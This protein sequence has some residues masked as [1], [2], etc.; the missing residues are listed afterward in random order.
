M[1]ELDM[2]V[3]RLRRENAEPLQMHQL[4]LAEIVRLRRMIEAIVED[5]ERREKHVS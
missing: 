1:T 5:S 3:Q 2:E 4:E